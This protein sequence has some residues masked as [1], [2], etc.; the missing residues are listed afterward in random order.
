MLADYHAQELGSDYCIEKA[1]IDP[2]KSKAAAGLTFLCL[3]RVKR[4]VDLLVETM[5]FDRISK[6]GDRP[7][8][9]IRL[10]EEVRLKAL[11]AETL[12]RHGVRPP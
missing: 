6:L 7:T 4:L 10:G 8:L 5:P 12:L 2:G 11:A 1:V 3:S 9:K